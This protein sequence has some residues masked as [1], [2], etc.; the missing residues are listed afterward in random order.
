MTGHKTGHTMGHIQDLR[1][2]MKEIEELC[3]ALKEKS[4]KSKQA[5][6]NRYYDD[7]CAA[8]DLYGWESVVKFINT[9]TGDNLAVA[10]YKSMYKRA[11][12]KVS[13]KH[14]PPATEQGA[15]ANRNPAT[16]TPKK[17]ISLDGI[18][19][20]SYL[21]ACFN[22]KIIA[23]EAIDNEVS[24]ETIKSWGCANFVQLSTAL[25]NHIRSKRK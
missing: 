19:Q 4:L 1:G 2:C 8:K 11:K 15:V 20:N 5:T 7:F 3:K 24:I 10:A 6:F 23:Q 13:I 9:E 18:D 21:Q 25:G 12:K 16:T 22:N 17:A 14:E